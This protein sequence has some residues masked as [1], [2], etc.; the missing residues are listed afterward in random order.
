V[1]LDLDPAELD[2]ILR[3]FV[4]VTAE[5]LIV[6]LVLRAAYNAVE[7]YVREYLGIDGARIFVRR[8]S[9]TGA[10]R[11]VAF[12]DDVDAEERAFVASEGN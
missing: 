8:D 12:F 3:P 2:K 1:K 4:D 7:I 9:A 11:V 10:L 5:P 6:E